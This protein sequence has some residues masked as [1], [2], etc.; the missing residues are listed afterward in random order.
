[1]AQRGA[2]W[3]DENREQR[4]KTW[5]E[6]RKRTHNRRRYGIENAEYEAMAAAQD[7]LC[8]V[9]VERPAIL[10]VEHD[11]ATGKVR[12]LSCDPCN[13]MLAAFDDSPDLIEA[14]IAYLES[15]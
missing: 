10:R 2:R 8:P 11:H 14:A 12:A 6:Y 7:G 4:R 13:W 5:R 15:Q 1:M 9:C 3:Q